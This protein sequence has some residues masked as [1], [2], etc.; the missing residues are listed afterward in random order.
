[1]SRSALS[2]TMASRPSP[3][4][5]RTF[6]APSSATIRIQARRRRARAT[7][8]AL[9]SLSTLFDS[10]AWG[11]ALP[12]S[13]PIFPSLS[14]PLPPSPP[15]LLL[16]DAAA[17]LSA[18]TSALSSFLSDPALRAA[19]GAVAS[20]AAVVVAVGRLLAAGALPKA[21]GDVLARVSFALL[22]PC[23]QFVSVGTTLARMKLGS[24]GGAGV[25]TVLILPLAAAV[26]VAVGLFLG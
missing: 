12:N 20:V 11:G 16:D 21:T 7:P 6:R 18:A 2:A 15:L 26:H 8:K 5:L 10:V 25:G 17:T 14:L 19:L 13:A 4:M 24:G 23:L 3:T 9:P 22:L 1:M